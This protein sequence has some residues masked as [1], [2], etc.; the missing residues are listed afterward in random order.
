MTN[1]DRDDTRLLYVFSGPGRLAGTSLLLEDFDD[2]THADGLWLY[3]RSFDHFRKVEAGGERV[4]VPGTSLTYQDARG[5]LASATYFFATAGAPSNDAA[6]RT[7]LA[8]PRDDALRETVG[9][10]SLRVVV[11]TRKSLV[12]RIDY[13]DLGGKPLKSYV[14]V[15]ERKQGRRWRPAELR[16]EHLVDGTLATL[17]YEHWPLA[18]PPPADLYRPD[19]SDEKFLPRLERVLTDAGLGKRIRTEIETANA[20]L[21]PGAPPR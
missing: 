1:G 3:L 18:K 15:R 7:L 21:A 4:M 12:R 16:A 13:T 11:D 2:P 19:V 5:F 10:D 8:C 9:Y 6:E 14:L 17:T 20:A